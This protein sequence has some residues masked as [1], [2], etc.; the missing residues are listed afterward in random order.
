MGW[1]SCL[2]PWNL[3]TLLKYHGGN[4]SVV[5]SLYLF[6]THWP[7][8]M[9][10]HKLERILINM[11]WIIHGSSAGMLRMKLTH[12]GLVTPYDDIDLGQHW[13]RLWLGAW[14]H[15]AITWTSVDLS[16]VKSSDIHLNTIAQEIPQPPITKISLKMT[17]LRFHLNLPGANELTHC[18]VNKIT[19]APQLLSS[20]QN[21][22]FCTEISICDP[23]LTEVYSWGSNK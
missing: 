14:R 22:F 11:I 12:C 7:Y 9:V 19:A 15:Q 1:N 6:L 8:Q 2:C 13:L 21:A 20:S 5:T 18:A 4:W 16:S 3:T 17:C 23:N 10:G